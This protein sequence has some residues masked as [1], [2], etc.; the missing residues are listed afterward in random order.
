MATCKNLGHFLINSQLLKNLNVA[1]CQ[2]KLQGTRYII[3]GVNRNQ[4]LQYFN[5]S[6]NDMSSKAYEF[7][8]K[9]AKILTRH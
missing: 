3:D 6:S 4:G 9:L 1:M 5:F 7:S 8:I 2:I